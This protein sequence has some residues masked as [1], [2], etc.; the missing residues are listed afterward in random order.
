V[1]ANAASEKSIVNAYFQSINP[2]SGLAQWM[3][4]HHAYVFTGAMMNAISRKLILAYSMI[5]SLTLGASIA[6]AQD[7]ADEPP[8]QGAPRQQPSNST[9][10]WRRFSNPQNQ[11]DVSPVSNYPSANQNEQ[12]DPNQTGGPPDSQAN[13]SVPPRL[14]LKAGTFVTVRVNQ[15]LSSDKNQPGDPFSATLVKPLIVDGV[16]V[17]DRGQTV[18]GRVA[19]TD[20]AGRVK[21]V[22]RLG[23]EL[24]ELSLVDGQQLPIRSEFLGRAGSTS[25]GR[26]ASAIAGTTALG[27]AVGAAADRGVGAAIG[28]GAGAAAAT[29]GV[30][31]TRGRATVIYP[32]TLLTFRI[33][34]PV[35]ISTERAPQAFRYVEPNDYSQVSDHRPA[36]PPQRYG[37]CSGYDCPPPP[38]YYGY[39]GGYYGPPFY[40][41]Y[42]GPGRAFFYGPRFYHGHRFGFR[43]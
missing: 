33:E 28:A 20:K 42:Y 16:V 43:R 11:P 12:A 41:P 7:Q 39:Y 24:T 35:T 23:V 27:A 13:Y 4:T 2:A 22:S 14:T 17:A 38:V 10:T 40:Y 37:P 34:S 29:V 30:L 21:G 32:E 36:P 1:L 5:M 25:V 26:D 15:L 6:L 9:G 8:A 18:G 19:E 31:L 3:L